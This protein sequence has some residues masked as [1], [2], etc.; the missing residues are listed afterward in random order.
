MEL[1]TRLDRGR[2]RPVVYCLAAAPAAG[3]DWCLKTLDAAGVAIH[4]LGAESVWQFPAI[5]GRLERLFRGQSP[6]LAQ[7]FLFHAN[8]AGRIAAH[9]AG[10]PRVVSGIR[11]AQRR[12]RWRLWLDR[13]TDRLVDRHVC[14]SQ[15]V[16]QF[17]A[18]QARLPAEKLVVIPNG[19][20]VAR[21]S[22]RDD[23]RRQPDIMPAGRDVLTCIGRLDRQK[24]IDWLLETAAI[25]LPQLPRCD[26]LL[27]GQGPE[28]RKLESQC[29]GLGIGDR[30]HFAGWRPDV[31]EILAASRLLV[32][33]SAWEGMPNVVL[34]AMAA[35]LPVVA[36]DAQGVRELLGPAAAA[37]IVPFGDTEALAQKLISLLKDAEI[38][39]EIGAQ[40]RRRVEEH[41]SLPSMVAAYQDL[42]DSLL[43]G[44]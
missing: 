14:A 4:C 17:A 9:R 11:V 37:Q 26:L 10:V 38:A 3:E 34:E 13:A 39:T 36:T 6:R 29:R 40:N 43:T 18:R 32:L 27:V 44:C 19:V 2:F 22:A 33:S 20:D 28:R 8:I 5:A 25:W 42:W 35:G 1:A 23:S 41:F 30:V 12:P 31:A 24:G 15:A 21:F 7:T 16:A